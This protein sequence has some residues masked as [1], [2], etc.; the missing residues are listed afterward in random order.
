MQTE[1]QPSNDNTVNQPFGTARWQDV[2][3][4]FRHAVALDAN[5]QPYA[6]GDNSHGQLGLGST[7]NITSPTRIGT[8]SNI[9]SVACGQFH[10]LLVDQSGN[11]YGAGWSKYG[12]LGNGQTGLEP[13]PDYV[14]L[15]EIQ[16]AYIAGPWKEVQAKGF[17][18]MGLKEDGSLWMWGLNERGA[19]GNG[20]ITPQAAPVQVFANCVQ[21]SV[22]WG[23]AA[24]INTEGQIYIWGDNSAYQCSVTS[25]TGLPYVNRPTLMRSN[26]QLTWRQVAVGRTHVLAV[27]QQSG[28]LWGWGYGA[29]GQLGMGAGSTTIKNVAMPIDLPMSQ[30]SKIMRIFAGDLASGAITQ[31]PNGDTQLWMWGNDKAGRTSGLSNPQGVVWTPQIPQGTTSLNGWFTLAL[32]EDYTLSLN[33]PDGLPPP[34]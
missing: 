18:S 4:H 11:L 33:N 5:G 6:W 2:S 10:T 21:A 20:T 26:T 15:F 24:V 31:A 9:R 13:Q 14:D 32:G 17:L 29:M 30:G 12:A 27:D 16:G 23:V 22:G 25:Q 19:V 1:Q 7:R 3:A 8:V 28:G 34:P